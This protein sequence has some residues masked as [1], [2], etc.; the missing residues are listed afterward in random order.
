MDILNNKPLIGNAQVMDTWVKFE[1]DPENE[2]GMFHTI[3]SLLSKGFFKA[4]VPACETKYLPSSF[5]GNL[6]AWGLHA[7]DNEDRND[8]YMLLS[9][10]HGLPYY[11]PSS[12]VIEKIL[13]YEPGVVKRPTIDIIIDH[14]ISLKSDLRDID[15]PDDIGWQTSLLTLA[16]HVVTA[17]YV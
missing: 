2:R 14:C 8:I 15:I 4:L 13:S 17:Q 12:G 3:G 9:L 7:S 6:V 1:G 5:V 16:K 11:K 10:I